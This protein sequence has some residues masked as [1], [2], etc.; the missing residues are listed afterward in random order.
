MFSE[1]SISSNIWKY[2]LVTSLA[3]F[4]FY[5]PIIQIFYL[6]RN[7]SIL[8]I[9]LLGIVWTITKMIF[10]L[11]SS[12]LADKWQRKGTLIIS[13][14]FSILQVVTLLFATQYSLF[15]LA[16]I[17]SAISYAFQSGTDVAFFYDTL[18][19]QGKEEQFDR[20][21]ARQSLYQQIPLFISLLASG[22][23]YQISPLFPFQVSLL[24][25]I[26]SFIVGCTFKE[27]PIHKPLEENSFWG[28]LQGATRS[29]FN[30][31]QLRFILVFSLMFSIGSDISYGYGQVYL[32]LLALPVVFFGIVYT[33]K[34]LLVTLAQNLAAPIR[35]RFSYQ[36]SFATQIIAMTVLFYLL[37]FAQTPLWGATIFILIA[38]PHGLFG[39]T[40]SAYMHQNIASH[41]RATV[42][43]LT[44]FLLTIVMLLIEPIIGY[45]ADQ[46][47]VKVPFLGIAISLTI[48]SIYFLC[49][50]DRLKDTN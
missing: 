46:Y 13:S 49:A 31:V 48:Y 16:S 4:A 41:H 15:I 20:L 45:L 40:K 43:S 50:K 1:K 27:P 22:F 34:S 9:A 2:Y 39:I 14:S 32:H 33:L 11:P 35:K 29:V 6:N 10:E 42:D 8:D 38:I 24:F 47:D 5:V 23:L 12:I 36:W 17:F 25:L 28:H 30:N 21:W 44:S 37:S 19:T 7:L 26:V 18:K 3:Q